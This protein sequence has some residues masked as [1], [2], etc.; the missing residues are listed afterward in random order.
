MWEFSYANHLEPR[1]P[2]GSWW[3]SAYAQAT[4]STYVIAGAPIQGYTILSVHEIS[5][6]LKRGPEYLFVLRRTEAPPDGVNW[7][8]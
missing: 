6:W 5:A 1:T 7:P 8:P 3:T 4:D 2:D